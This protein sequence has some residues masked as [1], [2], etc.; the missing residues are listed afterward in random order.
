MKLPAFA[1]IL[2]STAALAAP[3]RAPLPVLRGET[4][5]PGQFAEQVSAPSGQ[6]I[7]AKA[8]L[9]GQ[10]AF[11]LIDLATGEEV[12]AVLP[13]L[14]LPPASVAKAPTAFYALDRLGPDHVFET[15]LV[16]SG[17][18]K[19]G[20]INGDVFLV[21]GADPELDTVGLDRIAEAAVTA[22]LRAATG[23]KIDA[24][25]FPTF[26][27]I[28]ETQPEA[29]NY[30]PAVSPLNLNFNRAHFT[31]TR[32]ANGYDISVE[33]RADGLSPPSGAAVMR[34]VNKT[35]SGGDFDYTRGKDVEIWSVRK[36][37][38][39]RRGMR[40]LPVREVLSYAGDTFRN[41]A[42]TRGLTLPPPVVG[43]APRDAQVLVR[44]QSRPLVEILRD[45]LDYSTNLTAEV[46]GL[47]AT[48]AGGS[49]PETLAA[50]A[51]SMGAWATAQTGPGVAPLRLLNH[52]GLSGASRTSPRSLTALF[53]AADRRAFPRAGGGSLRLYNILEEREL[54]LKGKPALPG[55]PIVRAKTGTLTF[56][57]ALGGY[58]DTGARRF[59]FA[60]LSADLARRNGAP[61]QSSRARGPGAWAKRARL[62]QVELLRSWVLRYGGGDR[63]RG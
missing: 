27:A 49:R 45:M 56:A 36:G 59:A 61:P 37:A 26:S 4:P 63:L 3:D 53:A 14:A 9:S 33:A 43:T 6:S 17:P 28:N 20:K 15:K 39:G 19:A 44:L 41:R 35:R 11:I 25:L 22:G 10:T 2:M 1:L 48:R 5:R 23:F 55:A 40:W 51:A 54:T 21:G 24:S 38:L 60:I 50:S 52:S 12:E 62:M 29:A 13:D 42:R 32:K 47:A 16:A 31:W 34:V 7:L 18:Y 58:L 8:A 57:N 46:V 30:N